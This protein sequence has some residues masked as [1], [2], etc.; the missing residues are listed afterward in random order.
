MPS[1]EQVRPHKWEHLTVLFDDSSY[2][3]VSGV[4]DGGDH[5]VLGERWNGDQHGLGF[6]NVSGYAIWHV[7][8]EF[9]AIPIL[10]AL[11]NEL[12]AHPI[13]LAEEYSN[14]IIEE[15]RRQQRQR[16]ALAITDTR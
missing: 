14:R 3:I 1:A 4:Y 11:L 16:M 9:L 7:V 8:P 5:F 15:I 13:Q 2:S 6:P 12:V 10:E